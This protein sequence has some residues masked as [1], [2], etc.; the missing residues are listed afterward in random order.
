MKD[1]IIKFLTHEG[2]T[3]TK[4]ADEIGVQRSSI[5]HIL[6]GRNYP[7]YEFIQKMLQRYKM[8]NAEWLLMG[9]GS[10]FKRME[11]GN[12]FASL[13]SNAPAAVQSA[14]EV[15]AEK[16]EKLSSLEGDKISQPVSFP[17]ISSSRQIDKILVFYTDKTFEEFLPGK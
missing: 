3:A 13:P 6:S 4:F 17:E 2:L 10:M 7:S 5:S 15:H 1:R 12:L 9:N 16:P 11:Q 14:S 8:L